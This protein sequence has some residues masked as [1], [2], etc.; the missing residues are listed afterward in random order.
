[1][2]ER[3]ATSMRTGHRGGFEWHVNP[4]TRPIVA[5]EGGR[6]SYTLKVVSRTG[7]K[8]LRVRVGRGESVSLGTI[9]VENLCAASLSGDAASDPLPLP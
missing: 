2:V 3:L 8:T 4:S 1:M 9:R 7:C 5:S 6:E